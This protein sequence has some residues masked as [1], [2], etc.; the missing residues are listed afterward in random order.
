MNLHD[1]EAQS[2][3]HLHFEGAW[4][5]SLLACSPRTS[6]ATEGKVL[7]PL[8]SPRGS[9]PFRCGAG[10]QDHRNNGGI[11]LC[12]VASR[13]RSVASLFRPLRGLSLFRWL[14]NLVVLGIAVWMIR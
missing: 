12:T 11:P 8:K 14:L 7:L 5:S 6:E 2:L 4:N 10:E 3:N 1:A 13:H 9:I